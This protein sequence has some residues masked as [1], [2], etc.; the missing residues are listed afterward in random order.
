M[1]WWLLLPVAPAKINVG[2]RDRPVDDKDKAINS[3]K[4]LRFCGKTEIVD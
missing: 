1:S 3:L 2:R 4:S